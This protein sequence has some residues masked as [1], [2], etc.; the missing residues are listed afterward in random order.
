MVLGSTLYSTKGSKQ[1]KAQSTARTDQWA[2]H[3]ANSKADAQRNPTISGTQATVSS[4]KA[5]LDKEPLSSRSQ[6]LSKKGEI[7]CKYVFVQC[8]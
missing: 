4:A 3:R 5:T 6:Q 8:V 2:T 1:K 7:L